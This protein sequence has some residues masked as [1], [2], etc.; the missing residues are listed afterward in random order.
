MGR[1]WLLHN[2]EVLLGRV[3]GEIIFDQDR[4]MS[5]QHCTVSCES[6]QVWLN[7]KGS[8]NGSFIRIREQVT[9]EN[10][11]LILLGQKIFRVR[12]N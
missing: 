10:E 8:T 5:G 12:F 4:F 11:D 9:L 2:N 1:G 7:D 6:D 3:K